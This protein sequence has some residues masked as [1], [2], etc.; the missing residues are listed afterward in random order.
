MKGV[1]NM[2]R[3]DFRLALVIMI[4]VFLGCFNKD[5]SKPK[6]PKFPP[7][8]GKGAGEGGVIDCDSGRI[9]IRIKGYVIQHTTD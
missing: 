7:I 6:Y 4:V 2:K 3:E 1:K 8:I 5:I 9:N